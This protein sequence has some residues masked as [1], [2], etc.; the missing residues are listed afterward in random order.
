M[1][2]DIRNLRPGRRLCM[3]AA[4]TVCLLV[5]PSPGL[6][7]DICAG[8]GTSG[9]E[10]AEIESIRACLAAGADPGA[11]NKHGSPTPF[12]VIPDGSPLVGTSAYWR[13][14]DARWD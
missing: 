13:L 14:H 4:T 11:R 8:W 10:A 9:S 12:D 7:Q 5:G 2:I 3:A 1:K 6:A